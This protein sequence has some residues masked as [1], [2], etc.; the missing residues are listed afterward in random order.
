MAAEINPNAGGI[1][2]P[3]ADHGVGP[4][5][6]VHIVGA[7]AIPLPPE[8][9]GLGIWAQQTLLGYLQYQLRVTAA[10]SPLVGLV[11]G[12]QAL[13]ESLRYNAR[14][15]LMVRIDTLSVRSQPAAA[16]APPPPPGYDEATLTG[17]LHMVLLLDG[18]LQLE[19]R[20]PLPPTAFYSLEPPASVLHRAL[21]AAMDP[22]APELRARLS[23]TR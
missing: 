22:I 7:P 6:A 20:L 23:L 21:I 8:F 13:T 15:A 12:L 1:V 18:L 16:G 9:W 2:P 5:V 19:R 14:Y 3:P 11:N 4:R 17:S 10:A